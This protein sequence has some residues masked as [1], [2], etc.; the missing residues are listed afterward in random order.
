MKSAAKQED[1]KKIEKERKKAEKK[2]KKAVDG[3]GKVTKVTV[4]FDCSLIASR[5]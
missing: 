3:V 2:V 1:A 4:T 5:A